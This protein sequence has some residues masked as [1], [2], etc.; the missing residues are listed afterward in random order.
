M[1]N[2]GAKESAKAPEGTLER[3]GATMDVARL[4]LSKAWRIGAMMAKGAYLVG[5]R[6]RLLMK[7]G[8]EAYAR[9]HAGTWTE[10]ELDA[11]VRQLERI[12]KKLDIE[13]MLIRSARFGT[14]R[15]AAPE[16]GAEKKE[17]KK[18]PTPE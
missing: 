16:S 10:P 9:L 2:D 17:E 14:R 1:A 11:T 8:E 18:G 15:E 5:E 7:L 3:M 13:E 6:R 12:T 4:W